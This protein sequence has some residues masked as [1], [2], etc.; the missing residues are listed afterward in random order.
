TRGA[1]LMQREYIS[2]LLG[3]FGAIAGG[4]LGFYTFRW[5]L[6]QGFYG[7]IIPGAFLGLGCGMLARH[8]SIARGVLCGIAAL[9]LSQF[10]DWYVTITDDSFVEFIRNGK[11]LAPVTL[12]MTGIATLVAY[13]MGS[14]AG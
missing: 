4:A 1:W 9:A 11:T 13:W 12:L 8:R 7:L 10:A 14:D 2:N 3:L 5:L 6:G